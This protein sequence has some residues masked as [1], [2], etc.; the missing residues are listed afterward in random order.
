MEGA[1]LE[2]RARAIDDAIAARYTDLSVDEARFPPS[3][4]LRKD[5][6]L[7]ERR[8]TCVNTRRPRN[9]ELARAARERARLKYD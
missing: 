7:H 2:T 6:E 9:R 5:K 3:R 4:T 1:E 8:S